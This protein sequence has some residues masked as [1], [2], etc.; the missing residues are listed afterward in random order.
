MQDCERFKESAWVLQDT[1]CWRVP[2]SRLLWKPKVTKKLSQLSVDQVE[3]EQSCESVL[4]WCG[5]VWAGASHC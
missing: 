3:G 2:F 4:P 5:A 1:F